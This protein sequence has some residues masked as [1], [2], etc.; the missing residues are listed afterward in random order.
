ME[1]LLS[2]SVSVRVR[3]MA[4]DSRFWEFVK[5]WK[6]LVLIRSLDFNLSLAL[7]LGKNKNII[8]NYNHL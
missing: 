1:I 5:T 2:M 8:A 3:V 7:G 6:S 4:K